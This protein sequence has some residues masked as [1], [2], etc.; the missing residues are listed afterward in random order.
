MR[1]C[2]GLESGGPSAAFFRC[3]VMLLRPN[4]NPGAHKICRLM[5]NA[6]T[7]PLCIADWTKLLK[8]STSS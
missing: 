6:G 2:D 3:R 8:L 7:W 4:A 5:V 1:A